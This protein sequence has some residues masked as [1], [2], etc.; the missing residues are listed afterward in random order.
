M[1]SAAR[2]LSR[3]PDC[4]VT[5]LDSGCCGMAGSFGYEREHYTISRAIGERVLLPAIRDKEP[6]TPVVAPGFSCRHQ[7]EHFTGVEAHSTMTLLE[8]HLP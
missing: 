2:L 3:I 4:Q 5:V 7:I 1:D 8:T 6:D